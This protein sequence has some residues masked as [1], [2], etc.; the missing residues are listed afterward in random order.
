MR[1]GLEYY[2]RIKDYH[3]IAEESHANQMFAAD[4]ILRHVCL[5]CWLVIRFH[6]ISYRS[7]RDIAMQEAT[8]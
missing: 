3:R 4:L 6:L 8:Q 1:A 2:K 5:V 7:E